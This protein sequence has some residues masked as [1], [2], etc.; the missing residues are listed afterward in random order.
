MALNLNSYTLDK[1]HKNK[2]MLK[3][4][5]SESLLEEPMFID[6]Y[7]LFFDRIYSTRK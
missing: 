3:Y 5:N 1:N 4:D 2:T 7:F 6:A